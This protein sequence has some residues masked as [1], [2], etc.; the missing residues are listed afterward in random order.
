M[1]TIMAWI[2]A[3]E[4]EKPLFVVKGP[5]GSGKTSLLKT[6]AQFC[7]SNSYYAAGY[8]FSG[9][10]ADRNDDAYFM[11]T[12]AYQIAVAI[13]ELQPYISRVII[14]D[15]MILTRKLDSQTKA[16]LLNPL[17]QLRWD[18]PNFSNYHSFVIV[19]DAL[20]E[21]GNLDDQ[22]RVI[23]ALAEVLFDGSF[24][25]LCLLSSRFDRSIEKEISTLS[26]Y[27]HNEI[28]LG[29]NMASE[30][31][32]IGAY[33]CASIHR[34]RGQ[35][36]FGERIPEW[37]PTQ[38]DLQTI[39][40]R[41]GGQFI[42]A[43]TVIRYLDSPKHNPCE[44]LRD[45]LGISTTKSGENPFA[46]LDASYRGL[47]SSVV[48][49][50]TAIEILGIHL[51]KSSSKF[52]TPRTVKFTF[53]FQEHF[54]SLDADTVLAPLASVLKYEDQ[55]FEFYHLSFIEFLLDHS[56][57]GEFFV[58]LKKWQQWI[59]SRF[60]SFFYGDLPHDLRRSIRDLLSEDVKYLIEEAK[61]GTDLQQ[62]IND[63]LAL[64][65]NHPKCLSSRG[66]FGILP[67]VTYAFFAQLQLHTSIDVRLHSAYHTES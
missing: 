14:A 60:V 53:D 63:G 65:P 17:R 42:Y 32:D 29:K 31:A 33:L 38:S 44:R 43:S 51:V 15:P 3:G 19:V 26:A 25:F 57:S 46:E 41:S 34:I 48:N 30:D 40:V 64:V 21:C 16:L 4:R 2:S 20:D 35:H 9:T 24:P 58:D 39:I 28:I 13:P 54:R 5:A 18:F 22:R 66:D 56:R 1:N 12:I 67:F 49:I 45:I 8:F 52:W 27:I 61:P 36:P 37:W 55:N 62:A 50:S 47:M 59:V 6:V 23:A 10:D 11:N 7:E